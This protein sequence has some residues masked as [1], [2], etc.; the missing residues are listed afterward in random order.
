[1]KVVYAPRALRDIN[2]I[3]TY[4]N[5]RNP[6]GARN[7]SVAIEYAV[8]MCALSPRA[9]AHGRMSRTFIAV[10]SAGIATRFST[11]C[12]GTV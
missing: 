9:L 1:M 12:G 7:V 3:L 10:R 4:I 5:E 11:V 8:N 6:R 2:D